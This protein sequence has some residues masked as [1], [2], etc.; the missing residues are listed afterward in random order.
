MAECTSAGRRESEC[1]FAPA[2]SGLLPL[3]KRRLK[4]GKAEERASVRGREEH[5]H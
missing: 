3:I 4:R 5:I 2:G 1:R